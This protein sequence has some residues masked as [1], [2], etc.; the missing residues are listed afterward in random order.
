MQSTDNVRRCFLIGPMG[1]QYGQGE[2]AR[3]I[4]IARDI[5]TPL[6]KDLEEEYRWEVGTPS[7]QAGSRLVMNDVISAIDRADLVIGDLIDANPNVLYETAIAHALGKP[8]LGLRGEAIP[9]DIR[10][11]RLVEIS[12]DNPAR[13][14]DILR[15]HLTRIVSEI[16]DHV[17]PE[18]PITIFYREPL[19]RISPA[20][21][22]AQGYF[23]NFVKPAVDRLR[24]LTPDDQ[25]EHLY[26]IGLTEGFEVVDGERQRKV[27]YI[28]KSI[29]KRKNMKLNIVVP[30][31]VSH[32]SED[33]VA[34]VKRTLQEAV[35]QFE[36]RQFTVMARPEHDLFQLWDVPTPIAVMSASITKRAGLLGKPNKESGVWRDIEIDEIN[37]FY[38]ELRQWI[39]DTS[40]EFQNRIRIVRFSLEEDRDDE[41]GWLY[42]IWA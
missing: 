12:P 36:R 5:V 10:G 40:R 22:L 25:T 15:P 31:R 39:E 28:G 2:N 30:D 34:A 41:T 1:R 33:D 18:N 35:I 32:C 7:D 20:A 27:N 38:L 26:D 23:H 24:I 19:T 16:E 9:F 42:D 29:A 17:I 6:L 21:G 8:T 3:L 13:A 37:H 4:R 14:R 11:Y